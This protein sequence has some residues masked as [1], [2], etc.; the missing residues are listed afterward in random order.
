MGKT[1]AQMGKKMGKGR[2]RGQGQGNGEGQGQGES[3]SS[4]YQA[5]QPGSR[6]GDPGRS[7]SPDGNAQ[8]AAAMSLTPQQASGSRPKPESKGGP[9]AQPLAQFSQDNT[10]KPDAVTPVP[11]ARASDRDAARYPNAY[12]RLVRDYFKSVAGQK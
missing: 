9:R 10:E 3:A 6:P 5:P 1:L 12:R 7:G 2:G 8:Q 4:G 11:A